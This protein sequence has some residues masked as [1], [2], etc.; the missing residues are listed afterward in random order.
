MKKRVLISVLSVLVV[1]TLLIGATFA[2][3]TD[4]ERTEAGFKAGV[5]NIELESYEPLE[6]TNLRP[7]MLTQFDDELIDGYANRNTEGFNPI[8]VYFQP[9]TVDNKGTLPAR[10]QLTVREADPSDQ[11]KNMVDNGDGG[12][13]WDNSMVDCEN[14]LKPVL[15]IYVYELV[16][17]QWVRVEGVNLNTASLEEGETDVFNP[18]ATLAAN[19]SVTYVIGGHL[20]ESVGNEYQAEHFHSYLYVGAGQTDPDAEIGGPGEVIEPTPTPDEPTP[21]PTPAPYPVEDVEITVNFDDQSSDVDPEPTSIYVTFT[22]EVYDVV[23][24]TDVAAPAG[25]FFSP[26]DQTEQSVYNLE[27]GSASAV[28]FTV[29]REAVPTPT[30]RP[31]GSEENPYHIYDEATL[32]AVENEMDAHY[33]VIEDFGLVRGWEP[34]GLGDNADVPFTG[35]IDGQGHTISGLH[36]VLDDYSNVGLFAINNGTIENL[37]LTINEIEGWSEV[38]AVAGTN[39]TNGVIS[40]VHVTGKY[41]GALRDDD[42]GGFAGGIAGRNKGTI[43]YSSSKIGV[44]SYS[45]NAYGVVAYDYAGGIAGGNWGIIKESYSTSGINAGYRDE[46]DSG[47]IVTNYAGG[48][49][50]GNIGTIEDCYVNLEA[51]VVGYRRVGGFLGWNGS[52]GVVRRCY[53]VH[54]DSAWGATEA[55]ISIGLNAGSVS[56]SYAESTSTGTVNGFTRITKANLTNGNTLSGFNTSVWS[57]AAGR[58]PDLIHNPR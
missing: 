29:E 3:F 35:S 33:I 52:S 17:E 9:V 30:P 21:T 57:F 37:N 40:N 11:V 44:G 56:N 7:L 26:A 45:D 15:K 51:R 42:E 50:G 19:E 49:V 31:D 41:V 32:R 23:A 25:Y 12:I 4:V 54:N 55:S 38:G 47:D 34:L 16:G 39:D 18:A 58:Y 5:L 36:I 8:P 22:D 53:V 28:T 14:G 24:G 1:A 27:T 20:P 13:M 48:L 43:Q 10:L 46:I 2:W 6:F